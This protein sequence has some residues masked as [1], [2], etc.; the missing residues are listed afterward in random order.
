MGWLIGQFAAGVIGVVNQI[1]SPLLASG[2]L[3]L[4]GSFVT[5]HWVYFLSSL[6]GLG[7]FQLI[8]TTFA[9]LLANSVIV[10]DDSRLAMARLL[11]RKL[12]NIP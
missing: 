8:V 10:K 12:L 3:A 2:N 5:V 6:I 9:I 11:R 1:N 4:D 7:V